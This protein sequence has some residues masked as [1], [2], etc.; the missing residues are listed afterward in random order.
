MAYNHPGEPSRVSIEERDLS[1]LAGRLPIE[2]ISVT[3][4]RLPVR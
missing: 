2:P 1:G 4:L 3:L